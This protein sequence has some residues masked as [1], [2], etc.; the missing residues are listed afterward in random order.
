MA[1]LTGY[2]ENMGLAF[3]I[4]DDVLDV[5]GDAEI[6]G[7]PVGSDQE[8]NKMTYPALYGI[9]ESMKKAKELIDRA[10]AALEPF[11]EEGEPLREIARYIIS[12]NM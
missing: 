7:K 6:L 11:G 5:K 9:D 4:V 1:A 10:I 2:G 12:R 8:K 3:Q